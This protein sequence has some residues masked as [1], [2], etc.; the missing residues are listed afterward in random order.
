MAIR[1]ILV[2]IDDQ[3]SSET[4]LRIAIKLAEELGAHLT[5][6][7]IKNP[8]EYP[9]YADV[10][11]PQ[12][13]FDQAEE[14]EKEKLEVAKTNFDHITHGKQIPVEWKQDEGRT[15]ATLI[16]HSA[17][18]DLLVVSQSAPSGQGDIDENVADR[19]VLESGRPILV[20]PNTATD[21]VNLDR[22]VVAW[23]GKKEAV[24]AIHDA[25]PLLERARTVSIVSVRPSPYDDVPC[26]D[27]AKHLARHGVNV[28]VEQTDED[29]VD[30]GHWLQ[31]QIKENKA[32]LVVMGAYGHSRYR[33]MIFGGVTRHM[34]RSMPIPCLM[35]H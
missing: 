1:D 13:V 5:A 20:I 27:V 23:N 26:A 7:Y 18:Y 22:V 9:V 3:E 10:T 30:V 19:V 35:S 24:R 31:S 12:S 15:A 11:I 17:C 8:I 21:S 34:L 32:N 33:E 28:E 2:H 29:I 25:M 4:I 14:Y 16:E 6:L